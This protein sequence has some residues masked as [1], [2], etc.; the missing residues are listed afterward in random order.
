MQLDTA[1]PEIPDD[2]K[3]L[4]VRLVQI[5]MMGVEP[6]WYANSATQPSEAQCKH[7]D[8]L[9]SGSTQ[10]E[11]AHLITQQLFKIF[12]PVSSCQ[13]KLSTTLNCCLI[14]VATAKQGWSLSFY[15]GNNIS[16]LSVISTKIMGKEVLI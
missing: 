13:N 12:V 6:M 4:T 11:P 9:R 10:C 8:Q 7:T 2:R 16:F 15:H 5:V 3:K 1:N 14:I